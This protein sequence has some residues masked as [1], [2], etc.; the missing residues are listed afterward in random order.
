LTGIAFFQTAQ[1]PDIGYLS[2]ENHPG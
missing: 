1:L 2:I